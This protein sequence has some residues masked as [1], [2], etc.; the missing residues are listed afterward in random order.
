MRQ[1][2]RNGGRHRQLVLTV[3]GDL[4]ISSWSFGWES[5]RWGF[6]PAVRANARCFFLAAGT[7]ARWHQLEGKSACRSWRGQ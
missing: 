2:I 3:S 6:F 5:P 1:S 7:V 4:I